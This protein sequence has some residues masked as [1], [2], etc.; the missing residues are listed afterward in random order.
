MR[1]GTR[2]MMISNLGEDN[3]QDQRRIGFRSERSRDV[4]SL[5]NN[6]DMRGRYESADNY[7][8]RSNYEAEGAYEPRSRDD[9]ERTNSPRG[10]DRPEGSM[11]PWR[12]EEA[13]RR[14]GEDR[15]RERME[16]EEHKEKPQSN[17][18][19]NH[20]GGK[21]DEDDL[22]GSF[23]HSKA[24]GHVPEEVKEKLTEER[25]KKWV[26]GM[27]GSDGKTGGHYQMDQA[28]LLRANYC[29]TCNKLEFFGAINMIHSDYVEVAKRM[30]VDRPEFYAQMAK[31]FLM[32]KDAGEGKLEKYMR[33][34]AGK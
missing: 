21:E 17:S 33:H 23:R 24:Q 18:P 31:A 1:P 9:Y 14:L 34:I 30:N 6:D 2:M 12:R 29:P 4:R 10:Y 28:E 27:Q 5:N 22:S 25:V 15:Y 26:N 19:E 7:G 32:D 3:A 8:R 11:S 16:S 13:A 20:Y